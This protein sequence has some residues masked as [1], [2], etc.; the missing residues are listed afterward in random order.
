MI[1]QCAAERDAWREVK[2]GWRP[3]Y[4]DVDQF[5]VAVEWHDFRTAC[6]FD[7]G[8]S[9]HPRSRVLFESGRP[10]PGRSDRENAQ[11]LRAGELRLLRD[12]G[13]AVACVTSRQRSSSVRHAR[14]FEKS[15]AETV[16]AK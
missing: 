1:S 10:R 8:K 15:F 6:S 2:N 5:G 4:G 12:W 13:R 14:I 9:F 7:W 3:L 11:R 16:R